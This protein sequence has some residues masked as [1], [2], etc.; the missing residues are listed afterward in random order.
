MR[1]LPDALLMRG[2]WPEPIEIVNENGGSDLVLI[3]E[4]A[5]NHIP[6]E[7]AGLGLG[8]TDLNRHIAWDIGAAAVTRALAARLDAPAFLGT[9]SRLLIDLN[10]PPG[11]PTSIPE[12]SESTDIPGNSGL[13]DAERKRR[14]DIIFAPFHSRIA[15]HLSARERAGRAS[16]IVAMHSFTPVFFGKMRPWHAGVLY[17]S[18][19][20]FGETVISGLRRD[21]ALN[22]EPNVPY[23]IGRD[24]DYAVLVHGHDRGYPS[25]LIEVR[26]DLLEN[27]EGIA[28][29]TARLAEALTGDRS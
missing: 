26:Q 1:T 7:Y 12:R 24:H 2:D 29:W 23:V 9:Y 25:I 6:A 5:S 8:A 3:C 11:V 21:S 20:A 13:P 19:R 17:D 22:V 4:H 10:R 27:N 14:G 16:R 28:E 15:E 18:S